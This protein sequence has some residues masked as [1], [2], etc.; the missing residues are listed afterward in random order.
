MAAKQNQSLRQA[1][2]ETKGEPN[3]IKIK[4][5]IFDIITAPAIHNFQESK[6]A[7][8]LAAASLAHAKY[9]NRQWHIICFNLHS[10]LKV[11][12]S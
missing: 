12:A 10:A 5:Y 7:Q 3:E 11:S 1:V 9:V 4:S 6:S 2:R 8:S